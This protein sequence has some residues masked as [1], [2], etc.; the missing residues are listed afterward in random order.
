MT[1]PVEPIRRRHRPQARILSAIDGY[2]TPAETVCT[3]PL[4]T[5]RPQL[6][7]MIEALRRLHDEEMAKPRHARRIW[8]VGAE[9][10]DP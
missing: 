10:A 2:D 5:D 9:H 8:I 4:D 1:T 3:Y 6:P 7:Q